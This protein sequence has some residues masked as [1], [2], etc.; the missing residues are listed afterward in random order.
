MPNLMKT[1]SLTLS[2]ICAS[3]GAEVRRVAAITSAP[4]TVDRLVRFA[5]PFT[6]L[7]SKLNVVE[8]HRTRSS[9]RR[10]ECQRMEKRDW[11][12]TGT[13]NHHTSPK[14]GPDVVLKVHVRFPPRS[15]L[16][17]QQIALRGNN[18]TT[19]AGLGAY[20]RRTSGGKAEKH[21]EVSN[22]RCP[23]SLV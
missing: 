10:H 17:M 22:R 2:R 9:V 20:Y 19:V 1:L 13:S 6:S 5:I 8:E 18:V 11:E 7:F 23:H 3:A 15:C 21:T 16:R 4:N 14:I 12:K